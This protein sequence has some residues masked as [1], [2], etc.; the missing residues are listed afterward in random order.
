MA[1]YRRATRGRVT[2]Y[3]SEGAGKIASMALR[4][5]KPASEEPASVTPRRRRGGGSDTMIPARRG[6]F[7]VESLLVRLIATLG[8]VGI[9]VLIAAIMTSQH[10]QGWIVGL[11]VAGVTV[12][13][14]AVLWS[15]RQL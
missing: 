2:G 4:S 1:G 3:A 12:I 10:S 5:R 13:L 15:S 11:V 7:M 8:V 9:G 14:S 6:R